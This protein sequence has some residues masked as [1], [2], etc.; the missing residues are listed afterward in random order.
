MSGTSRDNLSW[1]DVRLLLALGRSRTLG[2]AANR[3]KIDSSTVSRRLTVLEQVLGATLFERGRGGVIATEAAEQLIPMAEQI[4]LAMARFTGTVE[5]LE[6]DTSGLVRISCPPD[7]AEVLIVPLLPLLFEKYPKLRIQLDPGETLTDIAR[8]ATDIAL[9]VVRPQLGNLV[10]TR[11]G[12][13]RW[14]WAASREL[15]EK[16][17]VIHSLE[18]V[19]WIGWGEQFAHTPPARWLANHLPNHEPI[20]CSDS[21]RMQITSASRGLGAIIMPEPSLQYYGLVPLNLS[22]TLVQTTKE[23]APVDLY[24]VTHQALRKVARVRAVWDFLYSH[25][26]ESL[27][28]QELSDNR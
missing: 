6:V 13:V 28:V 1:D 16:S 7:A 5:S 15:V 14:V 26:S 24:M 2:E 3:L 27:A 19:P 21:L 20:L 22:D 18:E 9:R 4:E 17:G 11:V 8:R 12:E 25:I 10:V 23:L